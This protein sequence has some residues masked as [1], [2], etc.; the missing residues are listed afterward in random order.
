MERFG[1]EFNLKVEVK[2][3]GGRKFWYSSKKSKSHPQEKHA[4][5]MQE[6]IDTVTVGSRGEN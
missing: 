4:L 6:K 5:N 1:K 2:I 3:E